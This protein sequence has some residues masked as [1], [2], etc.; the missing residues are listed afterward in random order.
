MN[1]NKQHNNKQ[2]E[3]KQLS[4]KEKLFLIAMLFGTLLLIWGSITGKVYPDFDDKLVGKEATVVR[5]ADIY[6]DASG[7]IIGTVPR[8]QKVQ[9]TGKISY[10]IQDYL[11]VQIYLEDKI[12]WIRR[13]DI[14]ID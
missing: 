14:D 2:L 12:V 6:D 4:N 10:Q 3:N 1:R 7:H 11:K 9:L 5:D 13:M 8:S